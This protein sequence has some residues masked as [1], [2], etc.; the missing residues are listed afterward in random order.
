M[1]DRPTAGELLEAVSG[2]LE[3]EILPNETGRRQFHTRVAVNVL[4]ILRREW[5]QEESMVRDEW[6]RLASLLNEEEEPSSYGDLRVGVREANVELSKR[7]RAGELDER[8]DEA[9]AAM[10]ATVRDKLLVA[11]PGYLE[12]GS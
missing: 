11:N 12:E 2:F 7:I 4:N 1:Q 5:E 3:H 9:V 10:A 6:R 8:W